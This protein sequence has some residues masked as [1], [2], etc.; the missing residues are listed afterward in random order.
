MKKKLLVAAIAVILVVTAITGASLAYLQDHDSIKNVMTVGNVTIEQETAYATTQKLLPA[1]I[2][3]TTIHNAIDKDIAVK[4]T[5][6]EDAYVRTI[7]AFEDFDLG[8]GHRLSEQIH[9]VWGN[10]DLVVWPQKDGAYLWI[11]VDGTKYTVCVYT[12]A[13][14]VEGG[15]TSDVSLDQ[16]YLDPTSDN[17]FFE[18]IGNEYN[19]LVL[20]Q[21]VQVEGFGA[22]NA[23]GAL[24]TAFGEVSV[25]NKETVATWFANMP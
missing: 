4:N 2:E 15:K 8:D 12:Y 24:N 11:E 1:V 25:A 19:I 18:K 21:A 5:G 10:N 16:I 6:S 9:T 14:P 3:G 7:F 17:S 20:S 22:N 13:D 23:A